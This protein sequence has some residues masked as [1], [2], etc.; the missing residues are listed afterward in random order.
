MLKFTWPRFAYYFVLWML[1]IVP[2]IPVCPE[3]L[4]RIWWITHVPIWPF[5][6]E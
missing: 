2:C 5:C 3:S 1:G 6:C 4:F